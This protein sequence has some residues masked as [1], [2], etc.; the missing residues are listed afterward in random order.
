MA[1]GVGALGTSSCAS[2]IWQVLLWWLNAW[3]NRTAGSS[4]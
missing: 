3:T 1:Q 4:F 2:L